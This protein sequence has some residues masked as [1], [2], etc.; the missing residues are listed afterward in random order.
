[1]AAFREEG[2]TP[3]ITNPGGFSQVAAVYSTN[4][5]S[6]RVISRQL[7][8]SSATRV[9]TVTVSPTA[10]RGTGVTVNIEASDPTVGPVGVSVTGTSGQTVT[11]PVPAGTSNG[12]ILISHITSSNN[13]GITPPSG[14]DLVRATDMGG[15]TW[16]RTYS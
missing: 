14:W 13:T 6:S 15:N 8:S 3:T 16:V 7:A 1:M 11:A 5:S 9:H 4:W 12:D 10:T 2:W